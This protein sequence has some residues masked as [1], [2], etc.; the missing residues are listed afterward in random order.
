MAF[1]MKKFSGFGDK[2]RISRAKRL[3]RKNVG[4]TT[5]DSPKGF[6]EK[7]FDKSEKKII[8]AGRL[9]HKAGYGLGDIEEAT[10]AGGYKAAMDFAKK[11]KRK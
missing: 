8:K 6:D 2:I 10:G 1:K 7:K 3:I 4:N 9:L 5:S 11:K